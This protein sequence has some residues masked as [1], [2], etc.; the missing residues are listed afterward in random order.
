MYKLE[1]SCI[2]D[3]VIKQCD[4]VHIVHSKMKLYLDSFQTIR[5]QSKTE[6]TLKRC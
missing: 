6:F 1:M 2:D 4:V 5:I 3:Q